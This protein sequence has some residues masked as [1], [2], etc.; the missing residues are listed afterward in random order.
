MEY[1]IGTG[2]IDAGLLRL[3]LIG[4]GLLPSR[5]APEP[6]RSCFRADSQFCDS[7]SALFCFRQHQHQHGRRPRPAALGRRPRAF[8]SRA[9]RTTDGCCQGQSWAVSDGRPGCGR[10]GAADVPLR[11][12]A[13]DAPGQA[14]GTFVV[15]D[16]RQANFE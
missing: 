5:T 9:S 12:G 2:L 4:A 15:L 7:V 3:G 14:P 13:G 6:R 8:G 10:G 1:L 16:P 11:F